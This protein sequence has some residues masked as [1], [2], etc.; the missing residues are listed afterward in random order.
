LAALLD[1]AALGEGAFGSLGRR[2]LDHRRETARLEPPGRDDVRFG[3]EQRDVGRQVDPR[4]QAPSQ[5]RPMLSAVESAS[6]PIF[7]VIPT[8]A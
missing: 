2:L 3:G 5:K 6:E 1:L 7:Y 4:E 8:R